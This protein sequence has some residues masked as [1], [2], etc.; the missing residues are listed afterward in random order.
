MYVCNIEKEAINLCVR[1]REKEY[2][3]VAAWEGRTR[4]NDMI[5]NNK[6][7]QHHIQFLIWDH[8]GSSELRETNLQG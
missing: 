6:I 2:R 4:E 1:E 8:M 3:Q 5:S 7:V